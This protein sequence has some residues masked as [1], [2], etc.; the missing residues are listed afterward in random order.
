MNHKSWEALPSAAE[1]GLIAQRDAKK[2]LWFH[3]HGYH[4]HTYQLLFHGARDPD[5]H[6]ARF[7]HLVAGRRGGKTLSAAEDTLYYMLHPEDY[8]L[9]FFDANKSDPL[10]IWELSKDYSIGFAAWREFQVCMRK[11]GLMSNKD[12]KLNRGEKHIEFSNGGFMQF[13]TA[14]DPESLRGQGLNLLW[15]DEAAMMPNADAYNVTYPGLTDKEGAVICTTTPKGKNWYYEEFFTGEGLKDPQQVTIE[16]TSID[17]PYFPEKEWRR[18][19]RRFHPQLFKQEFM[20]RFDSMAGVELN[21]EWLQYFS[22]DELP[23]IKDSKRLDLKLYV[24]IDPAIS[25]RDTADRFAMALIGITQDNSQAFLLDLYADRIPFPE[26]VDKIR[27]WHIKYRPMLIGI[28]SNAYQAALAQQ[29]MR[30]ANFPPIVPILSKGKKHE[31]ILSM[32]PYFKIGRIK[33]HKDHRDFV[34][35]WLNYDSSEKNPKDDTL[36]AV[37]IALRT[38]GALLPEMPM[39]SMFKTDQ[40]Q[41]PARDSDE[42]A[43]RD[44]QRVWNREG[45]S[46]DDEM[47]GEW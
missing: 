20:A 9:D 16:Y 36:D 31:R 4:P 2:L 35:E 7:R 47:G 22:T 5:G 44:L 27:E 15:M 12:Y 24:G 39:D 46:Y 21:G 1:L 11:A 3:D 33:I 43:R 6:I 23:R 40:G 37:E 10:W 41:M 38:A 19:Q 18:A 26:Q 25:V 29:A 13:K 14:V 30:M 32:A 17:N 42:L 45:G 28:E 8:W 34:D